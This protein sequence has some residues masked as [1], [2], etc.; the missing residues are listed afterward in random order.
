MTKRRQRQQSKAIR[1]KRQKARIAQSTRNNA[2]VDSNQH[3]ASELTATKI[4]SCTSKLLRHPPPPHPIIQSSEL[5]LS[6]AVYRPAS[7]FAMLLMAALTKNTFSLRWLT[8][9]GSFSHCASRSCG[10]YH[11]LEYRGAGIIVLGGGR[12]LQDWN[13]A[14]G[15]NDMERQ[16]EEGTLGL[17]EATYNRLLQSIPRGGAASAA[18]NTSGNAYSGLINLGNT[19]YL[20][21]QL[22]CAYHVPKV[23]ELVLGA[24]DRVVEVEVEVEV[25][26]DTKIEDEIDQ[27]ITLDEQKNTDEFGDRIPDESQTATASDNE[28]TIITPTKKTIVKQEQRPISP[29]LRALQHTFQSL[30]PTTSSLGTTQILCR[31][32]GINPYI[33]QDGQEFWKLFVPELDYTQLSELYTGYYD[34]YIREIVDENGGGWEEEKKEEDIM[35]ENNVEPRERVRTDPFLDLSIPVMEGTG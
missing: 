26:E 6:L 22:Q 2:S 33:Q 12:D 24:K 8:Q 23:R 34:D 31:S 11:G 17:S 10:R 13:A 25:E 35:R 7:L 27:R 5:P 14:T 30:S 16:E 21:A 28:S 19:C 4:N 15:R 1:R 18:S 9:L 32:L 20:N 29:A 3:A